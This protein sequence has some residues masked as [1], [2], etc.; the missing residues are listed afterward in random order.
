MPLP[1]LIITQLV[2]SA[3]EAVFLVSLKMS[4]LPAGNEV[5]GKSIE[6]SFLAGNELAPSLTK[7]TASGQI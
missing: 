1:Y 6:S 7:N 2:L 3:T 5:Y 4:S